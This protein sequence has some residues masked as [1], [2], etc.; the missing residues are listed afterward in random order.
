MPT[1]T[2]TTNKKT[3]QRSKVYKSVLSLAKKLKMS[4]PMLTKSSSEKAPQP[5]E[6]PSV[7]N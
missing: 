6:S 1:T 7:K 3:P 4:P 5:T 2:P